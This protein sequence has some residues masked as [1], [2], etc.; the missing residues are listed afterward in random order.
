[1]NIF[2]NNTLSDF[3]VHL[4]KSL[5][6][7]GEYE[8][9]IA[10]IFYTNSWFNVNESDNFS[11]VYKN[12]P[13]RCHA[14]LKP[15]FYPHPK[16]AISE[17]FLT[18]KKEYEQKVQRLS[19]NGTS[20]PLPPLGLKLTFNI[21]TQ[22][23]ELVLKGKDCYVNMSPQLTQALGFKSQR[24]AKPGAFVGTR[25]VD[26]NDVH[27]LFVYCDLVEPRIV[28]DVMTSLLGVVPVQGDSGDNVSIR[29]SKLHYLPILKKNISDIHISLRDDRGQLI[30][31]RR[32]RVVVTLHL[33]RRKLQHL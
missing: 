12:G 29:Y 33:R 4:P 32:G 27:G 13:V 3:K 23:A 10:E 30:K 25:L 16:Y 5:E 6:L 19:T 2:P 17:I 21:H 28:G 18:I 24:H 1:M 31:F 20:E 7:Q 8:V 22:V 11:F 14:H 9:A 15:G 26:L